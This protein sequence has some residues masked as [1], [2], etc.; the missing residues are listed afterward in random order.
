MALRIIDQTAFLGIGLWHRTDDTYV[1]CRR[2]HARRE[3]RKPGATIQ[4][5][6][7]NS[8]AISSRTQHCRHFADR[9]AFYFRV[10]LRSDASGIGPH[11]N[12]PDIS[13]P[14]GSRD[15]RRSLMK[16]VTS[17][18]LQPRSGGLQTAELKRT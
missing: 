13:Q 14:R 18:F 4:R 8:V 6:H 1:A 16:G 11:I 17:L 15:I 5:K 10:S 2:L 12:R 9:V 3:L 7:R